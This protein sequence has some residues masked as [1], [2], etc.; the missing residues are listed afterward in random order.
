MIQIQAYLTPNLHLSRPASQ[1]ALSSGDL[2]LGLFWVDAVSGPCHVCSKA[3]M[4]HWCCLQLSLAQAFP[5]PDFSGIKTWQERPFFFEVFPA[6]WNLGNTGNLRDIWSCRDCSQPFPVWEKKIILVGLV[7]EGW[8]APCNNEAQQASVF[9]AW[10]I[11]FSILM[12]KSGLITD[13]EKPEVCCYATDLLAYTS[14]RGT[15]KSPNTMTSVC[16]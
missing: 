3:Q 9:M 13:H 10:F 2:Y 7:T 15:T 11:Q 14:P 12:W 16:E 1:P 6:E 5:F 4:R 8:E